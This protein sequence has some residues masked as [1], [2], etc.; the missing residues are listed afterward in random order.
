MGGYRR[1]GYEQ[2]MARPFSTCCISS[3]R[4]AW[5]AWACTRTGRYTA[6]FFFSAVWKRK[7]GGDQR[8]MLHTVAGVTRRSTSLATARWASHA[9][10]RAGGS[11]RAFTVW[12]RQMHPAA[13]EPAG[14]G[15]RSP[16]VINL[17]GAAGG[18]S[19]DRGYGWSRGDGEAGAGASRA[20]LGLAGAAVCGVVSAFWLGC[21]EEGRVARADFVPRRFLTTID[22]GSPV[23]PTPSKIYPYVIISHPR[24]IVAQAAMETL[25]RADPDKEVLVV[26]DRYNFDDQQGSRLY[27]GA[28]GKRKDSTGGAPDTERGRQMIT[29]FTTGQGKAL[30]TV[31]S[32]P[33]MPQVADNKNVHICTTAHVI[34]LDVE[35]KIVTLSDG[36]V[37]G[38]GK[39]LLATGC[40]EAV[41]PGVPDS[42][43]H[44]VTNLR[45]VKDFDRVQSLA[46]SGEAKR[47]VVVGG[48]FL[49][50]EVASQL[51]ATG[52]RNGVE[53]VHLYVEPGA[54]YRYVPVYFADYITER[55]RQLGVVEKPYHMV[56]QIR[57][58]ASKKDRNNRLELVLQGFE[59]TS[60]EC[61]HVVF[62]PTH[63]EG[64]TL[65]AEEAGLEIDR[66]CGGVMVNSE[67]MARTDV[68]VAGDTASYPDGVLGR[69]RMQS[70]DHSYHSGALAA[71]NMAFNGRQSYHHLPVITSYG[72]PL[73][74][75]VVVLGDIDSTFE[76]YSIVQTAGRFDPTQLVATAGAKGG[77][78]GNGESGDAQAGGAA[79]WGM[80]EKG[81]VWYL[82]DRRVVGCM[83]L[84]LSENTEQ[85]RELIRSKLTYQSRMCAA[86][87]LCARSI[88]HPRSTRALFSPPSLIPPPQPRRGLRARALSCLS[89]S[90]QMARS[91][92]WS[93]NKRCSWI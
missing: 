52:K 69:R 88:P 56:L 70:Y 78:G 64:N 27:A 38:F 92:S 66:K 33:P 21:G 89:I 58:P 59:Q 87:P 24:A 85:V 30:E 84:N 74:M 71:S 54:L 65:L 26:A 4:C 1:S 3:I 43:Q 20:G 35:N 13:K 73:G 49:G 76:M 55:L 15:G 37:L 63:L 31:P 2:S 8:G 18:A 80:W 14:G 36:R 86:G 72:G 16:G 11:N 23:P 62:A 32:L 47:I 46:K 12:Q 48:G 29:A 19:G 7:E 53:V 81:I 9:V 51:Q 67:M 22:F 79:P 75:D 44:H 90:L 83:L 39:V 17:R 10:A 61:S 77:G 42:L 40:R 57:E 60:L 34:A 68:Y 82:K 6:V 93:W 50:C 45:K 25:T 41:L 5:G 28:F 91:G